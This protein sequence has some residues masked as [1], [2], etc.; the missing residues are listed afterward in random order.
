MISHM[1]RGATTP[2]NSSHFRLPA[3]VNYGINGTDCLQYIHAYCSLL[4]L[5]AFTGL[6]HEYKKQLIFDKKPFRSRL[7]I[8]TSHC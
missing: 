5:Q 8:S 4:A 6:S 7:K 1:T 2:T 3:N